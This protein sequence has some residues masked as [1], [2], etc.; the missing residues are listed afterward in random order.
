MIGIYNAQTNE[1]LERCDSEHLEDALADWR[2]LGYETKIG[3]AFANL[4][5]LVG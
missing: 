4:L 1:L 2:Q 5:I 3:S